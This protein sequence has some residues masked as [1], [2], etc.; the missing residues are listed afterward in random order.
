MSEETVASET[1]ETTETATETNA[2][3]S[4]EDTTGKGW[5]SETQARFAKIREQREEAKAVAQEE[6][7]ARIAAEARLQALEKASISKESEKPPDGLSEQEQID[8][9]ISQGVNKWWG[10]HFPDISPEAAKTA[11][12]GMPEASRSAQKARWD[13]LCKDAGI[14]PNSIQVQTYAKGLASD[15]KATLES[16]VAGCAKVFGKKPS[17]DERK[18]PHRMELGTQTTEMLDEEDIPMDKRSAVKAAMEGKR[19]PHVDASEILNKAV[20]ARKNRARA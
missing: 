8:W 13:A 15:P 7:E 2:E 12:S 19:S 1:T 17:K 4:G 14:D 20:R 6:R 9:R 16:M 10:K 5:N 3:A 18:P 11:L